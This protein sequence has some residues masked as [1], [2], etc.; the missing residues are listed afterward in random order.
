MEHYL[1]EEKNL[2]YEITGGKHSHSDKNEERDNDLFHK[3][4]E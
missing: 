3:I 2:T 4:G 1:V